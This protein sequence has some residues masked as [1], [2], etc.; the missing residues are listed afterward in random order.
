MNWVTI[1]WSMA[2]SASLAMA[3]MN[4]LIWWKQPSAR[5]NLLFSVTA[6]GAAVFAYCELSMMRAQSPA[7]FAT[8]LR[9]GHLALWFIVVS[10]V[11]FVRLYLRAGR[12]WLAWAVV[13]T[14]TLALLL[15][16]VTGQNLNHLEVVRLVPFS[17]FG[18]SVVVAQSVPNPWQVVAHV[19]VF[20][21]LA[22]CIDATV[23]VWRRGEH[24][25]AAMVGGSIVLFQLVAFVETVLV[26]W[27]FVRAPIAV[28]L[29][30]LGLVV[31]MAYEL[32][33]D[34]LR[35][36][37]TASD[38]KENQARMSL[39]L[40]AA[41]LGL[42]IRD[43][44]RNEIWASDE[45]RRLFDFAPSEPLIFERVLH[46][47]H[48]EDRD[49]VERVLTEARAGSRPYEMDFRL[50]LPNGEVRWIASRGDVECDT[51]GK[52]FLARGV[53]RDITAAKRSEQESRLLR[54]EIAHAGR[55]SLMGQLASALA[56]EISQPL[57]A[58][59]RNAE[60]A[61]LFMQSPS[62]DLDEIRAIL[63]DIRADDQ[64]AGMVIDR[65]RALLR[66]NELEARLLAV[67][68][69]VADVMGLVQA[70][71]LARRVKLS[72]DISS[73]LPRVRG[74]RVHLQQVLLNLVVN[75][76][77]ALEGSS[78]LDRRVHTTVHLNGTR[79][80]EIAVSDTG[81]GVPTDVLPRV[82]DPFYTT[83][84]TGMGIG[85]AVSRTIIEAHGGRI[86]A[87]NDPR[88]GAIFRFAL[89]LADEA[90]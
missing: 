71:A 80:V 42:W 87:E 89:P 67:D 16:F 33:G 28:S 47:V 62:P 79:M 83:K 34:V 73:G 90:A 32:I 23:T 68:E 4:L 88:G 59:L 39:A 81:P 2:A 18:E 63:A 15:N 77:D 37:Q 5:A 60:A 12:P 72:T 57:G 1:I 38:L 27:G 54:Q 52:P 56:H 51:E 82:F 44:R 70:D 41:S 29:L 19:N 69:F 26:F 43:F 64:R 7:D 25:R 30:F 53:S 24:R 86:W 50:L 9:W 84:P 11:G 58:I 65:M 49:G 17:L 48:P 78:R 40:G 61:D 14:R 21:L 45:W 66:R 46:R 22:F 31:A 74:D 20:L 3:A 75:G 35:A 85:L 36:A 13:G 76:M 6:I 55:V 8:A 10:L